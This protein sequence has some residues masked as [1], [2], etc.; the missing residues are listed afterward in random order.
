MGQHSLAGESFTS[1]HTDPS[2]LS[3]KNVQP[4]SIHSFHTYPISEWL[5]PC[6]FRIQRLVTE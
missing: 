1:E 4:T 6:C 2:G 3:D 5:T